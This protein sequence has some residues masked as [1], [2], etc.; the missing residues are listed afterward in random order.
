[1]PEAAPAPV[2]ANDS[3]VTKYPDQNSDNMAPLTVHTFVHAR[4]EASN[5][6]GKLVAQ[7][8]AGQT[9]DEVADH[10]GFDLIV[11]ADPND[12]TRKLEGW[13]PHTAFVALPF[14]LL[15]GGGVVVTDGGTP[16]VADAGPG[17]GPAPVA[18][19][20]CVKQTAGACPSPY[21]V[22]GAVCRL[23]CSAPTDCKGPN[24]K[25][26]SGKCYADNGCAN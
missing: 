14:H 13:A 17:P 18:G 6:S 16:V 25:C 22:S 3:D 1:M 15:D 19:Y 11:F 8:K 9:V 12:A 10:S 20:S 4:T 5:T 24:P 2:A 21:T 26:N 23:S 7:L